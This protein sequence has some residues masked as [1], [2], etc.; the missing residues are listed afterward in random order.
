MK[1]WPLQTVPRLNFAC[2][3]PNEYGAAAISAIFFVEFRI[4]GIEVD[5][6]AHGSDDIVCVP[7]R[8]LS[9]GRDTVDNLT[10]RAGALS[11]R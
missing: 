9:D 5:I 6:I 10:A 4:V 1:S 2:M 7:R 3:T 11:R 8:A